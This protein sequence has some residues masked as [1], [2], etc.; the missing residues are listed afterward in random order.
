MSPDVVERSAP[1]SAQTS[2][3]HA[4]RDDGSSTRSAPGVAAV[5]PT[6]PVR[7]ALLLDGL[8]QPA[9]VAH[10]LREIVAGGWGA[11]VLVILNAGAGGPTEPRGDSTPSGG[12]LAR[13]RG[14]WQRRRMLPYVAYERFD[15]RRYRVANDPNAPVDIAEMLDGVP[16]V[17]VAPRQTKFCDYFPDESVTA[18]AAHDVDVALRFGFRILKGRALGIAR[19]GIWS[20]HHGDNTVNRGGPPGLWEVLDGATVT[21]A[22]LQ[23][24]TEELDGGQVI[25]RSFAR[26]QVMSLRVNRANYY[27]Q[28]ASLLVDAV[29]R[30]QT[31]GSPEQPPVHPVA[32]GWSAYGERLY[33]APRPREVAR[34]MGR[35]AG[36]L[37]RSKL[38]HL[39][40]H[41]QWFLAY[42]FA[43]EGSGDADV[44]DGSPFRFKELMPPGDRYWA[45][46][47]PVV[48]DGRHFVFHEDHVFGDPCARISVLELDAKKG[49]VDAR[50][51]LTR[52]HHLSYPFVFEWQGEWY[53]T[54]ET[55]SQRA[56][57]LYRATRFPDAWEYVCDLLTGVDAVDPT[58]V[59]IGDRWWL[60]VGVQLPGEVEPTAL[61]LY[62]APTPLGPWEPHAQNPLM[63]DVRRSRPAGRVFRRGDQYFRPAQVGA[64]RYGSATVV[65]R[66]DEI[67]PTRYRET[68][69]ATLEPRWRPGLLGTHTLNAAGRLTVIDAI[70]RIPRR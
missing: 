7:L 8:T 13:L 49:V 42:R 27:W 3:S 29:R 40:S 1:A 32:E 20:F 6:A 18:I 31:T 38:R 56:V 65:F 21:G 36:R 2:T 14:Y 30:L 62:H 16:V 60:F 44:P 35:W 26:T 67:T 22:V 43:P 5:P 52:E 19:H 23:R 68:L 59:A 34:L 54:P 48:R 61:R 37:L 24:L 9:W 46:P 55:L 64:P 4:Q 50:P 47:F 41:E 25:A 12:V 51:A 58:I 15:Q 11:P 70:H 66:I 28:A 57:Q 69:V 33:V 63:V 53:M 17:R 39:S 10:V 45:D